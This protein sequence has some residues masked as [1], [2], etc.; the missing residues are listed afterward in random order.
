MGVVCFPEK[1]K[2]QIGKE[3]KKRQRTDRSKE[4]AGL[5]ALPN[6]ISTLHPTALQRPHPCLARSN[7]LAACFLSRI[8]SLVLQPDSPG[9]QKDQSLPHVRACLQAHMRGRKSSSSTVS[10]TAEPICPPVTGGWSSLRGTNFTAE[11]LSDC[12]SKAEGN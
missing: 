7:L 1:T 5:C 11:N 9:H 3:K 12:L 4:L 6:G 8:A 10:T 2:E